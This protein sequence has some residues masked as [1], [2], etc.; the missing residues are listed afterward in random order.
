MN[1]Q[2]IG[3]LAVQMFLDPKGFEEG[4]DQT[5]QATQ[6]LKAELDQLADEVNSTVSG[7]IDKLT[8]ST[9]QAVQAVNAMAGVTR[10]AAGKLRDA[11]GK[12]VSGE[13]ALKALGDTAGLTADEIA[14]LSAEADKAKFKNASAASEKLLGNFKSLADLLGGAVLTGVKAVAVAM[15]GLG[16]ASALVGAAFEQQMRQVGVIAEADEEQMALLTEE[17]RRLG[18]TTAFSAT[19]AADAMQLLASAGLDTQQIIAAAGQALVLAGAGGVDMSTATAVLAS[20]LSTFNMEATDPARIPDVHAKARAGSQFEAGALTKA[21][22]YGAPTAAA[23][24]YSLEETVAA[25]AQFRDM[26]LQGSTAGTALRS[27][28][29]Q[30]SQ[31]TKINADTLAKYNLELSDVNPQLHSFGDILAT[32]GA[33]GMNASDSMVVFGVEAGGAFATMAQQVALG[34]TK[35]SE[36]QISRADADGPA[37]ALYASMQQTD[38]GAFAERQSAAEEVLL[39]L[40]DQYSQSLPD[41][42]AGLTDFVNQVA[43]AVTDRSGEIQG[44][45]TNAVGIVTSY[46]SENGDSLARSFAD[47]MV[48]AAEF[49]QT[50]AGVATTLAGLIPY[51]DEIALTMGTIWIAS[52]VAAFAAVLSQIV[53]LFS[54]ARIGLAAFMAQLTAATGGIYALVVAIGTLVAGLIML[55]SR[56]D[57]AEEG[58]RKLKAAQDALAEKRATATAERAAELDAVLQKQREAAEAEADQLA[59]AGKL[60]AEKKKELEALRDMDGLT[61][62]RLE[63]EGKLLLVNNE[64]RTVRQI[65]QGEDGAAF[66]QISNTVTILKQDAAD[67]KTEMEALRAAIQRAQKEGLEGGTQQSVFFSSLGLS[68]SSI[69]AAEA[70]LSDLDKARKQS[71]DRALNLEKQLKDEVRGLQEEATQDQRDEAEARLKNTQNTAAQAARSGEDRQKEYT[72]ATRFLY[73]KLADE[74]AAIGA[75]ETDQLTIELTERERE[76]RDAYARQIKEA[77]GNAGEQARLEQDL[78]AT[79]GLLAEYGAKKRAEAEKDA[80]EKAAE[81]RAQERKRVQGILTGLERDGATEVERLQYEMADTLAGISEENIDLRDKIEQEYLDKIEQARLGAIHEAQKQEEEEAKKRRERWMDTAKDVAHAFGSIVD[82]VSGAVSGAISLVQNYLGQ[83]LDLFE[84]VTG[85]SFDLAGLVG[86]VQSAQSAAAEDGTTLSNEDAAAQVVDELVSGAVEFATLFGEVAGA[87]LAGLVAVVP[88]LIDAFLSALPQIVTAVT[89]ALPGLV[90]VLAASLPEIVQVLAAQMGIIVQAIA[91]QLPT[92]V[93]ALAGAMPTIAQALAGAMPVVV[94]A[95]LAVL[96]DI[97]QG[98]LAAA[99]ILIDALLTEAPRLIVGIIEQLPALLEAVLALLPSIITKLVG[100][101]AQVVVA[102]IK[103]LPDLVTAL[104]EALP[105]IITSLITAV[106]EALPEIIEAL[107]E[108]IPA[109]IVAVVE[110]LP[111]IL[112]ALARG[113]VSLVATVVQ[114][115]PQII[116]GLVKG[117]YEVAA[118]LI[119]AIGSGFTGAVD[120]FGDIGSN[121]ADWFKDIDLSELAKDLGQAFLDGIKS[122]WDAIKDLFSSLFDGLRDLFGGSSDRTSQGTSMAQMA[123]I[124]ALGRGLSGGPSLGSDLG[125]GGRAET[126]SGSR[127]TGPTIMGSTARISVMFDGRMVQDALVRADARGQSSV[128][129]ESRRAGRM[130]GVSR[131]KYNKFSKT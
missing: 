100:A 16:T 85:F 65:V 116:T 56:Y 63:A 4:A 37:T 114:Q 69:E 64:L 121:V 42:L 53:T 38:Q 90:K 113:M 78:Q 91:D 7:A 93:S 125:L 50:L 59:Q 45:L 43:S 76:I 88:D 66:R 31:Q 106:V 47:A 105:E 3:K 74:V 1:L 84:T 80:E 111:D 23:F 81:D 25:M 49:A 18:S 61:A 24:G 20:T 83:V 54:A 127:A 109:I 99:P 79:L 112:L 71:V 41:L 128:V 35:L 34:S 22:K 2:T 5:T 110:A 77:E 55:I 70:K 14:A 75:S 130:V 28:L 12:F 46:L 94:D 6:A 124:M 96:P 67:A 107:I 8:A 44:A 11:N 118:A 33:A 15:A 19:E 68:V 86:D 17:A 131:G 95:I 122:V 72:D 26:G 101:V 97:F 126:E 58:A 52:K 102:L 103:A 51:L 120:W 82:A 27:V 29:S 117:M 62:A 104:V 21:L 87:L 10:D 13:A 36:F 57:E 32:V 119:N 40:F 108:A 48:S 123:D 92:I 115:L 89:G 9:Q 129:T 73:E 39:T 60:T 98:L 30:A